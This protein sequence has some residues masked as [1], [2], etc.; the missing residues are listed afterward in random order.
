[1][2]PPETVTSSFL[3]ANLHC[4]TCVSTIKAAIQESCRGHVRWVS[5]NVVTSVV[6]VEHDPAASLTDMH[7]ALEESGFEVYGVTTTSAG[8]SSDW[9]PDMAAGRS[10][11]DGNSGNQDAARPSSAITRWITSSRF[12]QRSQASQSHKARTHLLHCEQCRNAAGS[13]HFDEKQI[14]ESTSSPP[15]S[16]TSGTPSRPG[17]PA[18]PETSSK[19]FI[20]IETD[21]DPSA[22]PLWRASLAIGGMTC[23]AC[24]NTITDELDKRDWVSKITVNLISNSAT[25][26]ITDKQRADDVVEAIEDLGYEAT[27]DTVVD[28]AQEKKPKAQAA[29]SDTWRA[30]VA[31]GGMTC[32]ACANNITKEMKKR[33][34]VKDITVNLLSNSATVEFQ[35]HANK[36]KIAEDIDALNS[37]SLASIAAN[38]CRTVK[39]GASG[40]YV[41]LMMGRSAV[42]A[43]TTSSCLRNPARLLIT[44]DGQ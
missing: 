5:P 13:P 8:E 44:R 20:V 22:Q 33:D 2:T 30:T 32:A 1:M 12:S 28:L 10:N 15:F 42:G 17:L 38:I 40:M 24:V 34:W 26:D 4:P 43:V 39:A 14:L 35:G 3:L 36:D 37:G 9:D 16:P 29:P 27:L 7:K 25:V 11:Y 6:T 31:I 19:S 18:Q 41:I 21:E 23:A